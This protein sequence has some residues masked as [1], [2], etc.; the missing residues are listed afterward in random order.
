MEPPNGLPSRLALRNFDGRKGGRPRFVQRLYRGTA[1]DRLRDLWNMMAF[2][3]VP[4]GTR[5]SFTL[6]A[7]DIP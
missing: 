7:D 2:M 4:S 3:S 6:I 1:S 5:D